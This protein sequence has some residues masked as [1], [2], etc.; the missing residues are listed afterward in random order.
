[1]KSNL[2]DKKTSRLKRFTFRTALAGSLGIPLVVISEEIKIEI[3]PRTDRNVQSDIQKALEFQRTLQP[4]QGLSGLSELSQP[5]A[6][7]ISS[8][9]PSSSLVVGDAAGTSSPMAACPPIVIGSVSDVSPT[10]SSQPSSTSEISPRRNRIVDSEARVAPSIPSQSIP[11]RSE[12]RNEVSGVLVTPPPGKRLPPPTISQIENWEPDRRVVSQE[13]ARLASASRQWKPVRAQLGLGD[14]DALVRPG[15]AG[16]V[17]IGGSEGA[18]SSRIVPAN[19]QS[20]SDGFTQPA[21]PPPGMT[22][23]SAA[24]GNVPAASQPILPNAPLQNTFPAPP[25]TYAPNPANP[26][27]AL[28]YQPSILPTYPQRSS[29]I[30][31]GEP[32][33]TAAPCQFDAYYMVEP[34][35]S[36]QNPGVGSCGPTAGPTYPGIPGNIAPPTIMP[37]QAPTG[38]YSPNNSGFRPLFGFGQD[39]F[40]VQLGRGIIGQPVAYVPGQPFRNFLR[41][42]F[43]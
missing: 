4:N 28:P 22:G 23:S 18:N 39:S 29:T 20:P 37:N 24:P 17:V 21:L 11:F 32:F 41:Y 9:A 42:I 25:T 15:L 38:I 27:Q 31:N 1:M 2:L 12:T 35:V 26:G 16:S 34:T 6:P 3:R 10:A 33:V 8:P 7:S 19:F 40:N 36:M 30:I 13:E 14:A 5:S 43:P